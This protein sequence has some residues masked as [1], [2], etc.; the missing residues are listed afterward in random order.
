[1]SKLETDGGTDTDTTTTGTDA[2]GNTSSGTSLGLESG[3]NN[4]AGRDA[5]NGGVLES[6]QI[7][8]QEIRRSSANAIAVDLLY[9]FTIG[10]FASLAIRGFWPAL[11]AAF[12]IAVLLTFAWLSSRLFF[13][14][15]VLAIVVAIAAT[16]AGLLA[17]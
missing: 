8:G 17:L 16:R 7:V 1:M 14:T 15:N 13:L 12:P 6:I 2:E 3:P 11:I 5:H 9:V 4:E 10:F